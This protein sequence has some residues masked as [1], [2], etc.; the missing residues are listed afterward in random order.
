MKIESILRNWGNAS[1]EEIIF[2]KRA[3][4]PDDD[5]DTIKFKVTAHPTW[6][7]IT[8]YQDGIDIGYIVID[9]TKNKTP[10]YYF[11]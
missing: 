11:T 1:D 2:V 7:D 10:Q 9:N 4:M 3:L 5:I 8:I 6:V